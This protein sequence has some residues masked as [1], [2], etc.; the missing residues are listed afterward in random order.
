MEFRIIP[1]SGLQLPLDY[2]G[3][4]Y[5][6]SGENIP[7][8]G[9][10]VHGLASSTKLRRNCLSPLPLEEEGAGERERG[11]LTEIAALS[12]DPSPASGRG[13]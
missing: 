12:P 7:A 1:G 3:F 13:E 9:I 5:T 4:L 6:L 10:I 11:L 2:K 8:V